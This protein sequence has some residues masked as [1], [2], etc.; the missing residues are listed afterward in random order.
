MSILNNPNQLQCPHCG[1]EITHVV[2][3]VG[4]KATG[5]SLQTGEEIK[6]VT[7]ALQMLIW[8][9]GFCGMSI[10]DILYTLN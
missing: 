5:Y 8:Y 6:D 9:C 10:L 2:K 7:K 3:D 1:Q 4:F